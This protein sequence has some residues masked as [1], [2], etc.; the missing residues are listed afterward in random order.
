M[1]IQWLIFCRYYRG[2]KVVQ[3]RVFDVNGKI[4]CQAKGA[5]EQPIF[6]GKSWMGGMYLIEVRQGDDV[7]ILKVVKN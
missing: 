7:K 4:I 2:H 5:P 3:V 6:F 1:I